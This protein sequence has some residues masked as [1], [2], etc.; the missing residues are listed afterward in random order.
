MEDII[1]ISYM[2]DGNFKQNEQ[3]R[4]FILFTDELET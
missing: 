3:N 1:H 4:V 2:K